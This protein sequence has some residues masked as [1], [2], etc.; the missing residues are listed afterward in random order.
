MIPN[1]KLDS[2]DVSR[3]QVL[4]SSGS[5]IAGASALAWAG[6]DRAAAAT[7]IRDVDIPPTSVETPDGSIDSIQ[8]TVVGDYQ[9]SVND[10]DTTR[11]ALLV[12][13]PD[14]EY[15]AIDTVESAVSTTS[16]SGQYTLTGSVLDHDNMDKSLFAVEPEQVKTVTF[17]VRV[18]LTVLHGGEPV[19]EALAEGLAEVAVE[20]GEIVASAAVLGEGEVAVEV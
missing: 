6:T 3:R 20:S 2:I 1:K 17:P 11:L 5:F 14:G 9:Y 19:V 16:G 12:A 4:M 18:R 10:A 7:D 8:A 15:Q 13:P